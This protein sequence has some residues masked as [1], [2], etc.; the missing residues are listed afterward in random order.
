MAESLPYDACTQSNWQDITSEHV[1]F[2]WSLDFA[3]QTIS[4][5]AIHHLRVRKDGVNEAMYV[6]VRPS[7]LIPLTRP[8]Q[9]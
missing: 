8:C 4:G 6:P 5:S 3:A 9:L 2:V 1:D 7:H